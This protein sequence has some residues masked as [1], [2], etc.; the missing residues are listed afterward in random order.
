MIGE[1][2]TD[3][4]GETRRRIAEAGVRSIDQVREGPALA[5]FSPPMREQATQLERF[6]NAELYRH[7]RV[8]AVMSRARAIVAELFERYR[9]DPALLPDEHRDRVSVLGERAIADYIAGMTDRFAVREH[10]RLTGSP[11]NDPGAGVLGGA[12]EAA[13]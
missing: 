5:A 8:S 7:E 13:P 11:W 2:V 9:S 4:I 6:L 1:L 3:L 12:S 10:A